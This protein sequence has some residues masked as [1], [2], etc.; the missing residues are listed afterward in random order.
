MRARSRS[1]QKNDI[2]SEFTLEVCISYAKGV[3]K[4]LYFQ[5]LK[6][7][8]MSIDSLPTSG[9]VGVSRKASQKIPTTSKSEFDKNLYKVRRNQNI[10]G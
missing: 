6:R 10:V 1:R 8:N 3:S 2:I 9:P 5:T 4:A 7:K